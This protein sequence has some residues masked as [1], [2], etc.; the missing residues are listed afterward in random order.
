V[1]AGQTTHTA[2]LQAAQRCAWQHVPFRRAVGRLAATKGADVLLIADQIQA[3]YDGE[4]V[5]FRDLSF[6]IV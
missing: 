6:S 5:L 2:N 3:T 4:R 1:R